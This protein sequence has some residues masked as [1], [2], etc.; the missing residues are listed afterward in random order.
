MRYTM[1][2]PHGPSG[3]TCSGLALALGLAVGCDPIA[4]DPAVDDRDN[5]LEEGGSGDDD[6][7]TTDAGGEGE[8]ESEGEEGCSDG[9]P[10]PEPVGLHAY[11][12]RHGDLP[13]IPIGESDSGGGEGG[14]EIDPDALL[15]TITTGA[16]GCADPYAAHVCGQWSVSFTLPVDVV[17]GEYELFPDLLGSHSV[18]GPADPNGE[19]WW[20]GG[21]L[22]GVLSLSSID[23]DTIAGVLAETDA[24]DFEPDGPFEAVVCH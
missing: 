22:S 3:L 21:S 14:S 5:E 16:D 23:D 15:V 17:P 9:M 7:A 8:A 1:I 19:C 11:A 10:P 20:G 18:S 13:D 2:R 4:S 6:A 12:I 24:F